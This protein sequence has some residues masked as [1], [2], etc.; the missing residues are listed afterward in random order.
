MT[1]S[2][3]GRVVPTDVWEKCE[4]VPAPVTWGRWVEL[5]SAG[6]KAVS[7]DSSVRLSETFSREGRD[8]KGRWPAGQD[9]ADHLAGDRPVRQADMAVAEGEEQAAMARRRADHRQPVRRRGARAEPGLVL[10][11]GAELHGALSLANGGL[12]LD[13]VWRRAERRELDARGDAHALTHGGEHMVATAVM[14]GPVEPWPLPRNEMDMVAALDGKREAIAQRLGE[15][16]RPA[17]GGEHRLAR[18]KL[19]PSEARHP[20]ITLGL[21]ALDRDS[22][23]ASALIDE[24]LAIGLEEGTGIRN[25]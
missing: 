11:A 7:D 25:R 16:M 5:A 8:I 24:E 3:S 9:L 10:N 22:L 13:R 18:P 23:D 15:A 6:A 4:V 1:G 14:D 12:D 21:E 19:P 20:K 2:V 17:A